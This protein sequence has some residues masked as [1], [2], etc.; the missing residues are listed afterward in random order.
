MNSTLLFFFKLHLFICLFLVFASIPIESLTSFCL[1]IL[2]SVSIHSSS[3]LFLLTF[4]I[5]PFL[6]KKLWLKILSLLVFHI[7]FINPDIIW[8]HH[9]CSLHFSSHSLILKSYHLKILL[10]FLFIIFHPL[11]NHN[12]F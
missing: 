1:F 4:L 12:L 5:N 11:L 6:L 9:L 7:V 3:F 8:W 10:F 2:F